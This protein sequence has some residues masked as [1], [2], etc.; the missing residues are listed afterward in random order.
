MLEPA[1]RVVALSGA[2]RGLGA[3]IARRLHGEGYALALGVRD[4]KASATRLALQGGAAVTF[5]RFDATNPADAPAWIEAAV[6]AHGRL[7]A[8][9]NNAGI[10]RPVTF[11]NPNEAALDAMW[12][13]NVKAPFRTIRAALPHLRAAGH[14]R[15][16]NIASTDGKRIRDVSVSIGYAMSK[17]ALVALTHAARFAGHEAGV[18]A[19][20]LC[21]GAIDTELLAGIPGVTP[22]PGRLQ[23]DTVA[24]IV[25]LLLRL[26]DQAHV[27]EMI[28]NTRLESTL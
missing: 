26:P 11:D 24:E 21:P 2:S 13:V 20:A 19:T 5:H 27:A 17:H 6:A 1:G 8:L 16:V 12:E 9:V 4:P 28:V 25:S 10:L 3:A 7:D 22:G 18:R 14:G 23:P 15:V